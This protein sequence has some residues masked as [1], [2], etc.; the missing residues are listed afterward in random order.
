MIILRTKTK[1]FSKVSVMPDPFSIPSSWT[2]KYTEVKIRVGVT[3]RYEKELRTHTFTED[4][5]KLIKRYKKDLEEGCL[6][7]DH[8]DRPNGMTEYLSEFSKPNSNSNPFH[9]L[10]KRIN[11]NDRFD[12]IVYPPEL[13][14]EN[15]T[16]Y[17][18][19]VIQSIVG[20]N[21]AG[22]RTYTNTEENDNKN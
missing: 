6:Y 14:E 17:Y 15:K 20:H 10:T 7:Y 18:P 12:Y 9:R 22:Q 8:P 19:V 21:I 11:L 13:D 16:V 4:E 1:E 2:G 5:R 3:D